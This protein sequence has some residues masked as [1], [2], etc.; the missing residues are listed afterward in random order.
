MVAVFVVGKKQ[1]AFSSHALE[2]NLRH[3]I[4]LCDARQY[5]ATN[6]QQNG[7]GSFRIALHATYVKTTDIRQMRSAR[8]CETELLRREKKLC[9]A[10]SVVFLF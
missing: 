3:F 6:N 5:T 10:S 7:I 9:H 2:N 4:C 8:V 1:G